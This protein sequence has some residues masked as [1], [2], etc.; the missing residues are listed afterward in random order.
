MILDG[1]HPYAKEVTDNISKAAATDR[2][3][4]ISGSFV[5]AAPTKLLYMWIPQ[6]KQQNIWREQKAMCFLLQEVR[7]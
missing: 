1:T 2:D 3:S 5:T 4:P 7:S 6:K